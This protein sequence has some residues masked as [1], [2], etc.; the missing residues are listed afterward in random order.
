MSEAFGGNRARRG[1]GTVLKRTVWLSPLLNGA[2]GVRPR[3]NKHRFVHIRNGKNACCT[4]EPILFQSSRASLRRSS[5]KACTTSPSERGEKSARERIF[6]GP[7]FG[8]PLDADHKS[9]FG[10]A[11]RLDLS[12]RRHSF[13]PKPRGWT[14]DPLRVE[15]VD[16]D[17]ARTSKRRQ[18]SSGGQGYAVRG[19]VGPIGGVLARAMIKAAGKLVHP[20]MQRTAERD[21]QLLDAAANRQNRDVAADRLTNQR[22][23]R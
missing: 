7:V 11:Y 14:I 6:P 3:K 23:C 16:H 18:K 13:D 5:R 12:I 22:Q 9:C 1:D 8:M 21:I 19:S 4:P 20:L 2:D 17:L 10:Q 15:G